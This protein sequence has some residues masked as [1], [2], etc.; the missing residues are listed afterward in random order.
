MNQLFSRLNNKNFISLSGNGLVS[1]FQLLIAGFIYH[2]L[3]FSDVGKWAFF[4]T[5]ISLC[6]A[7]R[8]G[9]LNTAT[10]KFYA[11]TDRD[12]GNE[13]LGSIWFLAIAIT[14]VVLL[15]NAG[16]YFLLPFTH[17]ALLIIIIKWTGMTVLSS[18]GFNVMYWKLQAE[19]NYTSLVWLKLVNS[20][21][22]L[23][24]FSF[25]LSQKH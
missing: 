10:V 12:R 5:V 9:S 4:L 6:D 20:S 3:S 13:V 8:N 14:G 17:N 22:T 11:G 16:A 23:L 1:V 7:A 25:L 18:L 15:L 2:Y 24:A 21:S 19:E